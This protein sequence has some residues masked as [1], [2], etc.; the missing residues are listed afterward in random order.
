MVRPNRKG[1]GR[2]AGGAETRPAAGITRRS[3]VA[4]AAAVSLTAALT[5][6]TR[7]DSP[8]GSASSADPKRQVTLAMSPANEPEAGFD[9]CVSWG[10]GEHVHEPLIQSTL[11]VTDEDMAFVN[12]LATAYSVSADAL[13]WSFTIR[14]DVRFSD[15]EALTARDV[16][17][18]LNTIRENANAQADFSMVSAVE[19]LSDTQVEIRLSKPYNVLL[20]TLANIGI[21]PEH[22]YGP[23][24][25]SN[26]VGSG[27]YRLVQWDRG[28]QAIFEAN[29][30]Y[31]GEAPSIERFTVV[32]M[33]ED[34]AL[35]AVRAGQVDMAYTS[36]T[37]ADQKVEGYELASFET[38]DS[39]GIN[40]PVIPAG[41]TRSAEGDEAYEAGNDVTAH[42]E[43]RQA[44]NRGIDRDALIKNVLGGH[45]RAAYSIGDGLPWA[46]A[47]MRVELDRDGARKLLEEAGWALDGDVY[48]LGDL[49]AELTLYYPSSD[50]V[51]QAMANEFANQ[52]AEIG[53]KVTTKGAGWDDIYPHQFSDPVMWG[54][55]SNAP[56]DVYEI[57]Y[58]S[59]TMNFSCYESETTD[60]YL[61][62]ALAATDMEASYPLWQKAEWDGT[63]GIAPAGAAT[64]AWFA[65]VDH[66]YW[67][68][69][70]LKIA[71][72]KLQ[73]HGHG[74]SIANNIDRWSWE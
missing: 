27:R 59:G 44:I 55:G 23:D 19:A 49:A 28:Q 3:L 51:R 74:W 57:N 56:S 8:A 9:P 5:A 7:E 52:M 58:S 35:A 17:F 37:F 62:A 45:G 64:W 72:Q 16:A 21:V 43:I 31:Y 11:I 63:E 14:E 40:L 10:C 39:R 54:W 53:I 13:T 71:R 66:L 1:R 15:G 4:G 46:S 73:P 60:A 41:Q 32:F 38:V 61:D 68:R 29:P 26:P 47:D 33:E 67:V 20:Y 36:A 30:S 22:A 34:A 2:A 24:Y 69:A 42:L 25:G 70:G 48:R 65:N 50:T 6:C 12:D 18:T